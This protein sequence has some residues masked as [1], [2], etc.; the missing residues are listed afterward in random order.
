MRT[1]IQCSTFVLSL[2]MGLSLFSQNVIPSKIEFTKDGVPIPNALVGG[3]NAPQFSEADFN[4][5]GR[6]DLFVFDR[7]GSVPLVFINSPIFGYEYAPE[8]KEVI[9]DN[10]LD[11]A[12]LRDFNCDG[13]MDLFTYFNF[14]VS[15]IL[16]YEGYYD[17]E[18]KLQFKD[19]ETGYTIFPDNI[20]WFPSFSGFPSNLNVVRG[21]IPAIDD[22]DGDSDMDVL[23]F[24]LNG[25]YIEF[26]ENFSADMGYG[27][28]SMIM[29]LSDNCWGRFRETGI[30]EEI[31]LSPS[32]DSCVGTDSFFVRGAES[33]HTGSTILSLD[34][35][36]DGDKEI[37]LGDVSFKSLNLLT[38]GY[39]KDTAW[40]VDQ[41]YPYPT[42]SLGVD[43]D[44][45]PSSFYLDLNNDG[46]KDFIAAPNIESGEN[47]EC[48]WMYTNTGSNEFPVFNFTTKTFLVDEMVDLGINAN[49]VFFDHNSD[50]LMDIVVGTGGL[51]LP[52]VGP[53]GYDARLRL[54]ENV[55]TATLP[56][57][58]L[59]DEDYANVGTYGLIDIH[60][61]FGDT[62]G[63]GDMDMIVGDA[64]GKIYF[65]KNLDTGNGIANFGPLEIS[66]FSIDV[67]QFSTPQLVDVDE[68]GKLD[69]VI[70]E[71][72]GNINYYLNTG[73]VS[74]PNFA[75]INDSWGSVFT[76]LPGDAEGFSQPQ[77]IKE[78]GSYVLYTGSKFRGI[79]KYDNIESNL[80]T[81]DF[82]LVA[83]SL[84]GL[85]SGY[86][87]RS[88]IAD[89]NND[90]GHEFIIG[91]RR[92]GIEIFSDTEIVTVGTQQASAPN[93]NFEIFPN[94]VDQTLNIQFERPIEGTWNVVLFD[95][96]GRQV[97]GADLLGNQQIDI[98]HLSSGIYFVRV[99]SEEAFLTKKFI[100]K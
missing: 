65:F 89:L 62:D 3:L 55:G 46:K 34:M 95:A 94:P 4:G 69:L 78:N 21:D 47:Y 8:Y 68:D 33:L 73:T 97:Y 70:G 11:F 85:R 17:S 61:T 37:V 100:K 43:I 88:N 27:C 20:L 2:L 25:G 98:P 51:Y 32:I 53:G 96:L 56:K 7:A 77:L 36:N 10:V 18:N 28:D 66:A 64:Q 5:D 74:I 26:Y 39:N 49:P 60:P 48:S 35:D 23:T 16:V 87:Y 99:A 41:A 50:G 80:I 19:F 52:I 14:A 71:K 13:A 42:N 83:D 22:I 59:I 82:N 9:P 86:R 81:G 29:K 31:D 6:M 38:N 84:L 54:Y 90:T 57:Y 1:L 92:G 58:A 24:G 15:G 72:N 45:F 40:M 30:S 63:D 76:S 91:N 93:F 67:G 75:L 12:L 44:I 79:M